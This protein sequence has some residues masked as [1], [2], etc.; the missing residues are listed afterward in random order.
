MKYVYW[1]KLQKIITYFWR[2]NIS[3]KIVLKLPE[4]IKNIYLLIG[5][6]W[7]SVIF[8]KIAYSLKKNHVTNLVSPIF[9]KHKRLWNE[10]NS[11]ITV[12]CASADKQRIDF[13]SRF[14]CIGFSY[15]LL[16]TLECAVRSFDMEIIEKGGS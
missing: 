2:I 10:A 12:R 5:R 9:I 7:F 14:W 11:G 3:V 1:Q 4:K 13:F 15:Y 16:H 6:R 8:S